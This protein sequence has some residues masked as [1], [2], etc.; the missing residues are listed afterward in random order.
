MRSVPH[1]TVC[2]ILHLLLSMHTPFPGHSLVSATA[3]APGLS[4]PSCF[5]LHIFAFMVTSGGNAHPTARPV[6][7]SQVTF[8]SCCP[9]SWGLAGHQGSFLLL[10]IL[11][12]GK[13]GIGVSTRKR[14]QTGE[15]SHSHFT[16][17][18]VEGQITELN[19]RV[20]TQSR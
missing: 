17:K 3:T 11:E 6:F 10:G 16:D 15:G 19:S 4:W 13:D 7:P 20:Y 14:W 18:K 8:Y 9:S 5:C 2:K 1:F 12:G